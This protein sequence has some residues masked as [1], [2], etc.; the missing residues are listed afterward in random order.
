MLLDCEYC[1]ESAGCRYISAQ[2]ESECPYRKLVKDRE[3]VRLVNRMRSRVGVD[4]NNIIAI[5]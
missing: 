1:A 5:L 2:E 3:T 4:T